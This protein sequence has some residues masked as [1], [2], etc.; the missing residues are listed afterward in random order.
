M[1]T[2]I[3]YL[4]KDHYFGRNL[5]YEVPFATAVTIMPRGYPLPLRCGDTIK[6]QYGMIGMA[7]IA[8][9]Y[10]L[11]FDATNEKGLSIAGLNFPENAVYHPPTKG[12][13]NITPFELTPWL[14]GNCANIA[15]AASALS[16]INITNINFSNDLL[17]TPLHWLIADKTDALVVESTKDGLEIFKNPIGVL[18]NSPPFAYHLH[19]LNNYLNITA[20]TPQNRFSSKIELNAYSRG[21]GGI[22]LPGDLS[23]A[24]RFVRAAFTKLN[25][26]SGEGE[27]ES[28]SQFFHILS[29][30]AQQRGCAEVNGKYEIT[31]YTSCC[32]TDKGVYYYTTYENSQITAVRML[33]EDLA[34]DVLL[35][36]P[37]RTQQS[38]Q[39]EN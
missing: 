35:A 18:T 19:N 13:Y 23:S 39:Y 37:I 11:F 33:P 16:Q 28:I 1:C 4:T 25:A 2:A 38:V 3:H 22:G 12:K 31:L 29:S 5:D 26:V 10:P 15:E 14:L 7:V 9:D 17:L 30:V 32:N 6:G 36:Y 34:G 24:S 27:H 20:G 21:M 8:E